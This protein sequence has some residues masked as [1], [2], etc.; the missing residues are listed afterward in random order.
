MTVVIAHRGDP[1]GF[2]ENTLEAFASAVT[3]GADMVE[4]DCKLTRDGQ[5]VVVH[6]DTLERLWGIPASVRDLDWREVGAI[7]S[8]GYRTPTLA[9]AVD[10]IAVPVMVD[11]TSA[12]VI[13][14]AYAIVADAGRLGSVMFAG[15]TA[16]LVRVR[17]LSG[18][19]RIALTWDSQRPPGAE[20]LSSIRPEWFNPYFQLLAP[21]VVRRH[22]DA[23]I[24]VSVWTVDEPKDID[25]VLDAGADAVISNQVARLIAA[26]SQRE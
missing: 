18:T 2:R 19:A 5:V 16:A 21:E 22:H 20:L 3:L 25:M 7:R 17:Q 24:G 14:A 9:E 12:D 13:E 4:L 6:D 15:A 8:G 26:V 1:V 23:G 10:A 11:V